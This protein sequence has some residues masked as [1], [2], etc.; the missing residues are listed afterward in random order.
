M[1]SVLDP[2]LII[3]INLTFGH[4]IS[5]KNDHVTLS[6][7]TGILTAVTYEPFFTFSSEALDCNYSLFLPLISYEYNF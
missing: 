7:R 5:T 1:F 3:K 6:D 2:M 4:E